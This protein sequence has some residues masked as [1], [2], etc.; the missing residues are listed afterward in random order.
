MKLPSRL[1]SPEFNSDL[2]WVR[3][4]IQIMRRMWTAIGLS[5][6]LCAPALWAATKTTSAPANASAGHQA[7]EQRWAAQDLSGT[8]S[9]V[10]PKM[11]LV[12][13]RD[14]SGVPFDIKVMRSTRIDAGAKREELSQLAPNQSV[15]VHF[16]PEANGDIART[17]Q[18]NR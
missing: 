2:G 6:A 15:S 12:V 17:I 1:D 4:E 14:S 11:N 3:R 9:M 13:V 18:V 16:V 8:I 7:T 10:D 5:I